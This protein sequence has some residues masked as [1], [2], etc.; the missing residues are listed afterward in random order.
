MWFWEFL[1]GWIRLTLTLRALHGL[2]DNWGRFD[3]SRFRVGCTG[4]RGWDEICSESKVVL[5]PSMTSYDEMKEIG[6]MEG[7]KDPLNCSSLMDEASK[8]VMVRRVY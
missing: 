2:H 3:F 5:M 1:K 6:R 7:D 4:G 8:H